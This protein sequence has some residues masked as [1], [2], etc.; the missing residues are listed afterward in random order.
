[1]ER[2]KDFENGEQFGKMLFTV[3]AVAI[4]VTQTYQIYG[5]LHKINPVKNSGQSPV[6]VSKIANWCS[7]C[8]S[9]CGNSQKSESDQLYGSAMLLL[10]TCQHNLTCAPQILL[11]HDILVTIV[12]KW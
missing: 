1:M 6:T 3:Y 10:G 12:R 7:Y 5:F 9:Q 11:N 8:G 2:I 4:N